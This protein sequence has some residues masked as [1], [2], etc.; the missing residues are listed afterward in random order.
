MELKLG[1]T[2]VFEQDVYPHCPKV[3]GIIV[4]IGP[5]QNYL[6]GDRVIAVWEDEN[7][8][9]MRNTVP[10]TKISKNLGLVS[11]ESMLTHEEEDVREVACLRM[12]ELDQGE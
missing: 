2:I 10:V 11:L 3:E 7:G 6:T 12:Q 1:D 4:M 5:I 9:G 8:I